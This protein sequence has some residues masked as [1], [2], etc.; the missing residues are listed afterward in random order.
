MVQCCLQKVPVFFVKIRRK[1]T[2]IKLFCVAASQHRKSHRV[3]V[4]HRVLFINRNHIRRHIDQQSI[5]LLALFEG[6][7]GHPPFDNV[8]HL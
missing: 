5:A 4:E 8:L 7:L 2:G 6:M 1:R 3:D